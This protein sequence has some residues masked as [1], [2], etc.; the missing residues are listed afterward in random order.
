MPYKGVGVIKNATIDA[1]VGLEIEGSRAI[2]RVYVTAERPSARVVLKAGESV[3]LDERFDAS[4]LAMPRVPRDDPRRTLNRPI[5]S[6]R[7]TIPQAP[8][9][10]AIVPNAVDANIPEPA[11][12]DRQAGR[13]RFERNRSSSPGCTSSSIDTRRA[14]RR[15][16]TARRCCAIRAT[17]AAIWRWARRCIAA[18]NT[19]PPKN[20][21]APPSSARPATIQTP[22]MASATTTWDSRWRLKTSSTRRKT[23][24]TSPRGTLPARTPPISNWQELPCVGAIGRR[25]RSCSAARW[26]ETP[27][28]T[29]Q[30][31]C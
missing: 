24:S 4:P 9:W 8:S 3:V 18:A 30:L 23:P 20:I 19:A 29:R 28:I 1:V 25:L 14:S 10:S 31:I 26:I 17:S 6:W 11:Q 7:F 15:I 2:A 16:I 12:R 27:G 21:F 5:C 13:A 22:P